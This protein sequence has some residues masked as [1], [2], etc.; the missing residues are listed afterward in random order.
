MEVGDPGA[1]S[2]TIAHEHIMYV[3]LRNS[4]CLEFRIGSHALYM[5]QMVPN[6]TSASTA[7]QQLTFRCYM[8]SRP[9][10]VGT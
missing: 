8:Q 4:V 3:V 10:F 6:F 9:P 1:L 7:K 5:Q 2:R